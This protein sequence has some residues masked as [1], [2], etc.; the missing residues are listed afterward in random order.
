MT[1]SDFTHGFIA[2]VF[3]ENLGNFLR[4]LFAGAYLLKIVSG[5]FSL[6]E[7]SRIIISGLY[8][9]TAFACRKSSLSVSLQLICI[10]LDFKV[11]IYPRLIMKKFSFPK[12]QNR[13]LIFS[14]R[15]PY[16]LVAER[17]ETT[18]SYLQFPVWWT[19]R[20]SN[21]HLSDP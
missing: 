5:V 19:W 3:S 2:S 4:G 21:P 6:F 13:Q 12:I 11:F 16:D 1:T 9:R 10:N 17:S 14:P 15:K 7:Y 18:A 8:F 20:A